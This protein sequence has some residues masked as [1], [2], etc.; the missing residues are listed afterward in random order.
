MIILVIGDIHIPQRAFKIPEPF[1]KLLVPGKI[2]RILCTGN[3][4]NKAELDALKRICKDIVLV[5]GDCDDHFQEAKE[6]LTVKI[7]GINFGLIHG[8]QIV[9]WGDPERLAA[10]ARELGCDVLV[11]GQTHVPS[12][13]VLDGRLF[14]NPG[15]ATGAF[16]ATE[17]ETKPSFMILDVKNEGMDI[18]LY[19][20]TDGQIVEISQTN[21]T[22]R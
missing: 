7:G 6:S 4:T 20:L 17:P 13:S 1:A 9:P 11:S 16:S 21:Y 8:H 14:L 15:S 3:I 12:V 18:Y 22:I 10:I 2:H 19:T 5:S